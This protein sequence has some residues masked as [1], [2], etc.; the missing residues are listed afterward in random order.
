MTVEEIKTFQQANAAKRKNPVC[1]VAENIRSIY[2]VGSFFRTCDAAAVDK[3]YLCGYTVY[4]PRKELEKTALGSTASVSWERHEDTLHLLRLK[5]STGYSIVAFEHA[6]AMNDLYD[7]EITFPLCA[8]FGNEVS[9]VT[10]DV[11]S[12]CDN[13]LYIPMLGQKESLNVSVACGVAL[14]EIIRRLRK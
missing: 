12:F 10:Q 4:P 3:L 14:Y 1:V 11:L 8:V 13:V 5:R 6:H 9:G 7:S 2:N